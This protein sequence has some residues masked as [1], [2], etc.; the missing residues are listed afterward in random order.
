VICV[1]QS[2]A[3]QIAESEEA[4]TIVTHIW[5]ALFS[6]RLFVSTVQ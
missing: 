1:P 5:S 6:L 4:K 3:W 2:D